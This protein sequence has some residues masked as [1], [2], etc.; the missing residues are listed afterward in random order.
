MQH[1]NGSQKNLNYVDEFKPDGLLD[2]FYRRTEKGEAI[3]LKNVLVELLMQ[4]TIAA[5]INDIEQSGMT[6]QV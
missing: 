1:H 4:D 2:G 6:A 5:I 3:D